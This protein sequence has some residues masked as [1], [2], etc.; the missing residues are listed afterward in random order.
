MKR[1]TRER[2]TFA[3]YQLKR[4][5]ATTDL[6]FMNTEWLK[7]KGIEPQHDNY[8][9]VYTGAL[10]CDGSQIDKLEGIYRTFNIDHPTDFTGH[11]LSVSDIVAL[12]QDGVVS[13]YY[14]DSVG[15]KELPNFMKAEN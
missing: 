3:I 11:S 12:N 13:C 4:D 5:D 6:R 9:L 8:E 15:Y 7:K 2:Y 14:V 10:T 1:E